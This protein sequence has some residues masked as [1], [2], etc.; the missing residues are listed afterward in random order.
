MLIK[1]DSHF[2]K[3]QCQSSHSGVKHSAKQ[4]SEMARLEIRNAIPMKIEILKFL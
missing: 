3:T 4:V 1:Y 2:T